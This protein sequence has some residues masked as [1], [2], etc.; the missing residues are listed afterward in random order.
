MFCPSLLPCHLSCVLGSHFVL[1]RPLCGEV[2]FS[3]ALR[4][5]MTSSFSESWSGPSA[6]SAEQPVVIGPSAWMPG[7]SCPCPALAAPRPAGGMLPASPPLT[8]CFHSFLSG[9]NPFLPPHFFLSTLPSE[10]RMRPIWGS[11]LFVVWLL[12]VLQHM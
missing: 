8:S 5:C 6:C 4:Y 9:F 1:G 3:L 11:F 2:G 7:A 10:M 12:P